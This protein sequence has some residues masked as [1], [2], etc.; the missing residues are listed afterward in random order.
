MTT[1]E[2]GPTGGD[3]ERS[4]ADLLAEL[5]E[6]ADPEARREITAW[7]LRALR[8]A[9]VGVQWLPTG[10]GFPTHRESPAELAERVRRAATELPPATDNQM[11][12]IRLPATRHAALRDWCTEHGFSMAA[13][14][15]GLVERFLEE[16]AVT[17]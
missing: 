10:G 7:L 2:P 3:R 5:L 15:R 6:R 13:V 8:P 11:V 9:P 17:G 12:T 4:P 16:Q 14:V 1:P